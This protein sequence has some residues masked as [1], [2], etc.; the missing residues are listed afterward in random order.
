MKTLVMAIA[1]LIV[2]ESHSVV[3]AQN[4]VAFGKQ[5][6]A[7]LKAKND[8]RKLK[9]SYNAGDHAEQK[10]SSEGKD[11]DVFVYEYGSPEEAA[12]QMELALLYVSDPAGKERLHGFGDDGYMI[13]DPRGTSAWLSIRRGKRYIV[14][15]SSRDV[16]KKFARDIADYLAHN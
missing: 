10:W 5:I 16:A 8:K 14:I 15:H 6:E 7:S 2:L 9:K 3:C 4:G 11:V 13:S 12:H 1:V